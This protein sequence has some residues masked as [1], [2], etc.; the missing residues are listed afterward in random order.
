MAAFSS[1]RVKTFNERFARFSKAY[2]VHR[3]IV[4]RVLN[5]AFI[6]YVLGST[7]RGL[8]SR[9]KS[10]NPKQGKGKGKATNERQDGETGKAP[11]VAVSL[12]INCHRLQ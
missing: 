5:I 11:R 7:Y 1:L 9:P 2:A 8:S 12:L 3:P 6:V 10:H 4:Q